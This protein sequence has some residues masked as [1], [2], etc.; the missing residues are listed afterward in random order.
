MSGMGCSWRSRPGHAP[1]PNPEQLQ[2]HSPD[3]Q[4][5]TTPTHHSTPA[6]CIQHLSNAPTQQQPY[7]LGNPLR[8]RGLEEVEDVVERA[9]AVQAVGPPP[10]V[11]RAL[12]ISLRDV[13]P[14]QPARAGSGGAGRCMREAGRRVS[15]QVAEMRNAARD[16]CRLTL[17]QPAAFVSRPGIALAPPSQPPT[18][19]TLLLARASCCAW[20]TRYSSPWV[21]T[22]EAA[23][24][25]R[26]CSQRRQAAQGGR[27]GK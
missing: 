17:A 27:A 14:L 18:P 13:G 24:N 25:S 19:R 21:H 6:P 8:T 23:S 7:S 15:R 11:L 5:P 1:N 9:V 12:N 2:H 22:R 20:A 10:E 3:C 26:I 4:N 16:L